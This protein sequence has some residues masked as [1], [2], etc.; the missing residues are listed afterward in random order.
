MFSLLPLPSWLPGLPSLE[1]GSSLLDGL[2]QGLIGAFGVSV[3]NNLLKVYFFVG[4]AN[5]PKRQ[6][7]TERLQAQ[8]ALL[9]TVHL[10]GL[11]LF[12]TIVG[13]RVAALVV[14]EF[15]LRAVSMLLSLHKSS[16]GLET[17]QLYLLSQYALGCA[18]GCG[19]SF[20]QEGAP[21]RTLSLLLS[22]GL[23][24]LIHSAARRLCHHVC[25][26]YELHSSQH[27]CGVCLGLLAGL[28][29]HLRG[30]ALLDATHHL[31][32]AAGHLHAGGAA[33]AAPQHAEPGADSAGAHGRPF[34]AAAD[35]G[36]LAGPAEPLR[37][38][39]GRALVP[40][41]CPHSAGPLPD[42]GLPMPACGVSAQPAPV[43]GPHQA[44]EDYLPAPLQGGPR[45]S[46]RLLEPAFPGLDL[47]TLSGSTAARLAPPGPQD[48]PRRSGKGNQVGVD[49]VPMEDGGH[50]SSEWLPTLLASLSSP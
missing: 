5:D 25:R 36:P 44:P 24:A 29:E 21:H 45:L 47:R 1:W 50:E 34:R 18:L 16:R 12:L 14:L 26:L 31:L 46:P 38:P 10:V 42:P 35:R 27:Y 8:W 28:P 30:R 22:L 2:L 40:G 48:R 4:C 43:L 7:E 9:E 23:A 32:H 15:S 49:A 13:P 33:A 19:L 17:L 11:A 20:L 39:A 6:M 3:L 41:G 37:F